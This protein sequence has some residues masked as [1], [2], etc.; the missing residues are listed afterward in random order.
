M[1][2]ASLLC[3]IA[4]RF[5]WKHRIKS[6]HLDTGEPEQ[7]MLSSL[8]NRNKISVDVGAAEGAYTARMMLY[9]SRVV[10]FE[11][12]PRVAGLLAAHFRHTS[13]VTVE[14]VALSNDSGSVQMRIPPDRPMLGTIEDSN[15]LAESPTVNTIPVQRKRLDD[16][17]LQPVGFIKI[18]VEGHEFSVLNGAVQT[19][20]RERPGLLI[21]IDQRNLAQVCAFLAEFDYSGHFLLGDDLLPVDR[22]EAPIHQNPANVLCGRRQGCYINN[23]VFRPRK[24]NA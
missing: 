17:V 13:I 15:P 12:N 24:V 14:N 6:W 9:S 4:P 8:C 5:V 19:I 20:R 23:F 1:L 18:D 3:R 22:F 16:Y 11:P 2:A 10:A 21:E 7:G